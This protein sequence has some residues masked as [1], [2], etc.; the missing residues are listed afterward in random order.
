MAVLDR[1]M[2]FE[3]ELP[4]STQVEEGKDREAVAPVWGPGK[5]ILFRF[6]FSYLGMYLLWVLAGLLAVI[7]F[8]GTVAGWYFSLWAKLVP[9]AGKHVLHADA[10][11]QTTGSGDSTFSWVQVF[12][13]LVLALAA[14]LVWT[15]LDRKRANYARLYEWLQVSVRFGLALTMI[16]Y[17]GLKIFPSQF[18]RPS[19]DRL[20][21]PFGDASPMGLLWT[22]MGASVPYTIF[23]G[24]SEWFGGMLLVFRRTALLGSLVSIAVLTNVVMLNY[25]YDVPV[26]L[27]SSHLLAMAI[28]LVA[29]HLRRLANLL[30]LNRPVPPAPDPGLLRRRWPRRVALACKVVL[31][32]GFSLFMVNMAREELTAFYSAHSPLRG[33]WN[34]DELQV[35]GLAG[36]PPG[37]EVLQ[38][39]RVIFDY[40]TFFAIQLTSDSRQRYG[41]K[42]DEAKKTLAL[43]KRGDP[44]W[45]SAL[46][47]QRPAP[48]RLTLEGTFEGKKVRA[49]LH[50]VAEP[51]SLL[52]IRGFH[53]INEFPFNY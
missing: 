42:L 14:T 21:Q 10:P 22:F 43:T 9:W 32:V 47:Y 17:G 19:L 16:E 34:V 23:S 31:A 11:F 37:V 5:R 51:K 8:G 25:C 53:W 36:P 6:G 12:C 41:L 33:V 45:K 7:P 13:F 26:K 49:S 15:A 38:W 3:P 24:L 28:F 2:T 39:R 44:A 48:D 50:R 20:L 40:Q 35:D 29:P 52:V 18:P 30:V 4:V 46:T 1:A 27:F